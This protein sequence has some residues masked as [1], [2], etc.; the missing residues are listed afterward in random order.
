MVVGP[1]EM[2]GDIS[3]P[4]SMEGKERAE[5]EEDYGQDCSSWKRPRV[6]QLGTHHPAAGQSPA[7]SSFL[8]AHKRFQHQRARDGARENLQ[9]K[10]ENNKN[11]ST[12]LGGK[13]ARQAD[14]GIGMES[15]GQ[16]P[17]CHKYTVMQ[18]ASQKKSGGIC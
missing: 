14:R 9:A 15:R 10:K 3:H 4:P 16:V 6:V 8:P 11:Q 12:F 17:A 7:R 18:S 1:V 5:H 2:P 13:S